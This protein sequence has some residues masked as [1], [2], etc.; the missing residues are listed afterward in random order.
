[1]NSYVIIGMTA[2]IAAVLTAVPLMTTNTA[3]ADRNT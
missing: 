2:V 1:M 3:N